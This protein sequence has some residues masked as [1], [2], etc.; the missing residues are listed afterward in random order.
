MTE[1]T[2]AII[3][4]GGAGAF[5]KAHLDDY[6]AGCREAAQAGWALLQRGESA[7]DVVEAAVMALENNPL[8]N[9]GLGSVLNADG[10]VEMDASIMDGTNLAAGA[11]AAVQG[12]RNPIAL[13]RKV[14]EDGEHVLL[15]GEGARCFARDTGVAECAPEELIVERQRCRWQEKYGTVGSVAVDHEGRLA[16]AT[17]TGGVFGKR[18]GRVGDSALI[19][20]GTFADTTAAVSCTGIGEAIIRTVLAKTTRG[21]VADG[22]SPAEAAQH[23]VEV[24]AAATGSEAG[25]IVVDRAGRIG[26]ARNTPYMPVALVRAGGETITAV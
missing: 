22:R 11:V 1:Q 4:H 3:V 16:A 2:A 20:C 17:S 14:L 23:A 6:A 18:P 24:L 12:I 19:G 21:L 9:A 15:A 10:G 25:L 13:A 7:V 8:F 26:H 5:P